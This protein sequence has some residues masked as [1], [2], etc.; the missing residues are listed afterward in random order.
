MTRLRNEVNK[1]S[2]AKNRS[3]DNRRKFATKSGAM[4]WQT[5]YNKQLRRIIG[6]GVKIYLDIHSRKASVH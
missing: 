4:A 5:C 2:A 3:N 1:Y 6:R